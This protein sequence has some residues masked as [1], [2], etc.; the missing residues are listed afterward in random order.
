M[1][2]WV[3]TLTQYI[4][5]LYISR[6]ES[7]KVYISEEALRPFSLSPLKLEKS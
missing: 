5:T 7:E 3:T 1:L 2:V 6:G 4:S